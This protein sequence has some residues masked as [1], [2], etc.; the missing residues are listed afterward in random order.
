MLSV[1]W[2]GA[3]S[4]HPLKCSQHLLSFLDKPDLAWKYHLFRSIKKH[5][6][7]SWGNMGTM[8][9]SQ[10][11]EH[12]RM[13]STLCTNASPHACLLKKTCLTFFPPWP[14]QYL[15]KI[16]LCSPYVLL[17]LV[18]FREF[19]LLESHCKRVLLCEEAWFGMK[20]HHF[21]SGKTQHIAC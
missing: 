21:T 1:P 14:L 18:W 11:L 3:G 12:K 15:G 7:A 13:E 10:T 4:F 16:R 8:S 20:N 17:V 5:H 9:V 19:P 2:F 6:I